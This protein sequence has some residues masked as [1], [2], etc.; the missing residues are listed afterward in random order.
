M[1]RKGYVGQWMVVLFRNYIAPQYLLRVLLYYEEYL[2]S[3]IV[4]CF[5]VWKNYNRHHCIARLTHVY[6]IY[7]RK[8]P[9][10]QLLM[11]REAHVRYI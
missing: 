1:L 2:I 4:T 5:A 10:L 3:K 6:N 8:Q 11:H 7:R 9:A